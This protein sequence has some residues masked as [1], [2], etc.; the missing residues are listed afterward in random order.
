HGDAVGE[1]GGARIGEEE[2]ARPQPDVLGL[3]GGVG[4][5]KRGGGGGPPGSGMMLAD[6]AF[7]KTQLV[8]PTDDLQVPFV[9]VFE[10]PFRRM[11][12]HG[13]ISELHR[14]P[15]ESLAEVHYH[16]PAGARA[17]SRMTAGVPC[18]ATA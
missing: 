6:P 13:E 1:L 18:A 10:R 12:R 8:E 9:A 7:G 4:A 2:T 15:P 3:H 16:W 14:F 17:R 5:Q 11:R